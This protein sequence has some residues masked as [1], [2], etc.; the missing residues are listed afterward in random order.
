MTPETQ[1]IAPQK[2]KKDKLD[3]IHMKNLSFKEHYQE[4]ENSQNGRKIFVNHM[5]DKA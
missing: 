5:Y 3:S 1:P 4:S 2:K